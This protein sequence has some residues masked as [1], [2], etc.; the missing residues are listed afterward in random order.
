MG[1][2]A[3]TGGMKAMTLSF[4]GKTI[5]STGKKEAYNNSPLHIISGHLAEL[6]L[7]IAGQKV[8]SKSNEIPCVRELIKALEV[9]GC[10]IVGDAMHCQK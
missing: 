5:C 6:G 3:D 2:V 10:I 1:T 4:D 9:S 8:D 7:T